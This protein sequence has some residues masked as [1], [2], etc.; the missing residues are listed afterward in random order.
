MKNEELKNKDELRAEALEALVELLDTTGRVHDALLSRVERV[1]CAGDLNV[2]D[3]VRVAIGPLDR[4]AACYSR[5]REK[6]FVRSQ[7]VKND[8]CVCGVNVRLHQEFLRVVMCG[9]NNLT[10]KA[11]GTN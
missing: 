6:R 11:F 10:H 9:E 5:A 2:D 8:G 4:L 3:R 7:V 1:R